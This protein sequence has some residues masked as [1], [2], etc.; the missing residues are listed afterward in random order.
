MGKDKEKLV[1]VIV[2]VHN[3]EKY[4]KEAV[5][6]VLIQSYRD[7]ELILVE[8]ESTDN[9]LKICREY[10]E[11]YPQVITLKEKDKG[12]AKARNKGIE[13]AKGTYLMF[14]DADDYLADEKIIECFVNEMEKTEVDIVVCNYAR[15]WKGKFLRAAEC[16]SLKNLPQ[17]QADF[18]FQGFFSAGMLSYV[19][20]KMY[21]SSFIKEKKITFSDY[22]Y[23]EDKMFNM[24]C[25]VKHARYGF[26][27]EYGYVYRK[28]EASISH[29]YRSDSAGCWLK[30]AHDMQRIL[31]RQGQQDYEDLVR[32]TI[33]FAS[34]FDAK[35]EY[36]ESEKS[37]CAVRKVLKMYGKDK[38]AARCFRQMAFGREVRKLQQIRWK[39]MIRGFSFAMQLH[40][41]GILAL[42]IKVLID[43]RIDERLSDT[44]LRE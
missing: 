41:Y 26:I 17:D 2:P 34:F 23:A 30:I 9:S 31:T 40:L 44:G 14:L 15:L 19:W 43:C 5:E 11:K 36:V 38:L 25:Y 13:A 1:S 8:N 42:G 27:R 33:F 24:Q 16:E 12:L 21:R 3:A 4:L 22:E 18:R 35:M 20:G 32:Y 39:I 6:S 37:V 28:N 10:E 7:F 29:Q